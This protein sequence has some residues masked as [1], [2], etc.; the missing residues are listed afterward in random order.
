MI[1]C[2]ICGDTP[3]RLVDLVSE[4]QTDKIKQ[5]CPVCEDVVNKKLWDIKLVTAK[6]NQSLIKRFMGSFRNSFSLLS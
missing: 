4:Y 5:I 1:V 2:D 6:I 3:E